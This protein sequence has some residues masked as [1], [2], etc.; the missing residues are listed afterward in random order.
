MEFQEKLDFFDR[1]RPSVI[2]TSFTNGINNFV[3]GGVDVASRK[4]R[5]MM[6]LVL[7]AF[8]YLRAFVVTRHRL[9]L[10]AAALRQ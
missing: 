3:A 8:V 10:E 4:I 1:Q 5:R 2:K 6:A 9:G 7:A